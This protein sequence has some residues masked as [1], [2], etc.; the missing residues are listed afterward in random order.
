MK[1]MNVFSLGFF[2]FKYVYVFI[3]VQVYNF[4]S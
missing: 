2:L 1:A 4:Y 3:D